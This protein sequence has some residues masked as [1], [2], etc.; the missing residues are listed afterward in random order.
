MKAQQISMFPQGDDLPLFSGTASSARL[1]VFKPQESIGRQLHMGKCP[2]CED[3]GLQRFY[4]GSG[5]KFCF[6]EA[7]GKAREGAQV[8]KIPP[9]MMT[10]REYQ[11]SKAMIYGGGVPILNV[12]DEREHKRIIRQAMERGEV[13]PAHVLVKYPDLAQM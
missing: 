7:G 6:C 3:T 1:E 12:A 2:L 8:E 11:E 13:I 10:Q 5:S 9:W 4:P